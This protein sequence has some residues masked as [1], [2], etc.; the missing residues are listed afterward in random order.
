MK[1]LNLFLCVS[2]GICLILVEKD[3]KKIKE[4]NPFKRPVYAKMRMS[5]VQRG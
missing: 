5:D 3:P 4:F 1:L 2:I